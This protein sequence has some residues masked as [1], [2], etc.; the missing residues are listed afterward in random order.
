MV[1]SSLRVPS[2]WYL[3]AASGTLDHRSIVWVQKFAML[4]QKSCSL[5]CACTVLSAETAFG[6]REPPRYGQKG[7]VA[8][9]ESS[10]ALR[11]PTFLVHAPPSPLSGAGSA[12]ERLRP[13]RSSVVDCKR[14][15]CVLVG[16]HVSLSVEYYHHHRHRL[17]ISGLLV[18]ILQLLHQPPCWDI[19]EES[20]HR[21]G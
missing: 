19:K 18:R 13:R 6:P 16:R 3:Q 5:L 21:T 8:P 12:V 2:S 15:F 17:V 1:R 11:R 20:P 4:A 10:L 7:R 9:V 14:R